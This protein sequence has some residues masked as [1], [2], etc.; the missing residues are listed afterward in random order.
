MAIRRA[1]RPDSN[2][3]HL[4]KT[5]SEDNRLSWAARGVLVFLLGKPDDWEV[6]VA[7]LIKQTSKTARHSGRDAILGLLAE[8]EAAG[9]VSKQPKRSDGQPPEDGKKKIKRGAFCGID[10]LV[11]ENGAP[12]PISPRPDLTAPVQQAPVNPT[13]INID[14]NQ[15]LKKKQRP[16]KTPAP[17]PS[18]FV[19]KYISKLDL[20][21]TP[22]NRSVKNVVGKL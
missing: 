9:Y 21:V 22:E 4:D 2:F 20:T 18:P 13:Q 7:H 15:R 16:G 14:Y 5:I 6:S 8:L 10:Y 3:Y 17:A 19:Q 12:S 11:S 1:P